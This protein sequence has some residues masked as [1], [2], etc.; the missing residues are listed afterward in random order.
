M[1]VRNMMGRVGVNRPT[2]G[3]Y[4]TG[5]GWGDIVHDRW[6]SRAGLARD[7]VCGDVASGRAN[8]ADV[9]F[10]NG[11]GVA[12]SDVVIG[13]GNGVVYVCGSVID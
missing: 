3:E 4:S 2:S 10:D 6:G 9:V 7:C 12:R 11:R 1:I 8:R 13:R 5:K